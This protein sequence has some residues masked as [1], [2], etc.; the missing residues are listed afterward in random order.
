MSYR[1]ARVA[2]RDEMNDFLELPFEIY[3]DNKNWVAPMNSELKRVLDAKQNPYF[4][5]ASLELFNCYH[6]E[7]IAARVMLSVNQAYCC[8]APKK[9]AFFGFFESYDDAT[10]AKLLFD[11]L[12]KRCRELDVELLEGPFN[13]N[14]Y[15]E[16]GMLFNKFD[17]PQSFFQ[18]YNPQYY[19]SLMSSSRFTVSKILHTRTNPDSSGYLNRKFNCPLPLE[20]D[21]L[22][23]RSFDTKNAKADLEHLRDIFND[24]FSSNWHF[25]SV[26][27]DEYLFSSKYLSL[28][29][30]PN[31]LTFVER[32]GVPIA[33][34]HFALDVN[35]LLREL[36]GKKSLAKYIRFLMNRRK[37]DK[38]IIFA[39]GT[40]KEFQNSRVT[41]ML[42]HATVETA[43]KFKV[44]ETTW[45]YDDNRVIVS[46]AEKLGLKRDKEFVIYAREITA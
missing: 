46:I 29:T 18:T 40:K 22:R 16:V 19:H 32:N 12:H 28:V 9:T 23:A 4:R 3:R 34:A 45:M 7:K 26:S 14:L 25:T 8:K 33:A 42:F 35:P 27:K 13:P 17:S 38:A 1:I 36:G 2:S 6:N 43:R 31:L 39:V 11:H 20:S 30:P 37:I 21:D 10:A 15:S 5:N 44:L 41:R 24:A